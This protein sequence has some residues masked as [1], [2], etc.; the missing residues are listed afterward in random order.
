M[1]RK[2]LL[3]LACCWCVSS[4]VA[5][6]APRRRAPASEEA[7]TVQIEF[8]ES[9]QLRLVLQID[10][11]IVDT[12]Y[13][14]LAIPV[15]DIRQIE[16]AT[17]LTEQ[18]SKRIDAAIFNLG[19]SDFTQREHAAREL[20]SL[21][22]KAYPSL[23]RATKHADLEVVHRAQ[24]LVLKLR[25]IVP[26]DRLV[27]REFDVVETQHS[28][29][30]G[31]I[32]A[33]SIAVQTAQFGKQDLKLSDIRN[34]KSLLASS[35]EPDPVNVLADP[36]TLANYVDKVGHSFAFKVTGNAAGSAWGTGVYTYDTQLAVAAVHAGAL[37]NGET[38]IVRITMVPSPA[39]FVGSA[40][41]GVTSSPWGAYPAAYQVHVAKK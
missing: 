35:D 23:V 28:K 17:R 2:M 34:F 25:E 11:L 16:F 5:Q 4:V 1:W 18:E 21:K 36:G 7:R 3:C 15:Q 20:L 24:E 33:A 37:K 13:G 31:K 32:P 9:G 29:I 12:P 22:E 40:Q 6:E 19:S 38:G 41:N 14:Q 10:E 26:E 30:S 8:A 27:V 39:A